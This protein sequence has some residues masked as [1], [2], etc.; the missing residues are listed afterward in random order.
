MTVAAE[1]EKATAVAGAPE[2]TDDRRW[3]LGAIHLLADVG[4]ALRN[5][6][7]ARRLDRG[8][9]KAVARGAGGVR[10]GHGEHASALVGRMGSSPAWE[11]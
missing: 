9:A 5:R 1:L 7:P 3:A 8:D 11:E 10:V 4:K 2:D 6:M